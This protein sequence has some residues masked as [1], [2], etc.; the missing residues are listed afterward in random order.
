M[1]W[2]DVAKS[3][4]ENRFKQRHHQ[5]ARRVSSLLCIRVC[6]F[7][8]IFSAFELKKS[9]LY[10]CLVANRKG[11]SEKLLS[12]SLHFNLLKRNWENRIVHD[13]CVFFKGPSINMSRTLFERSCCFW[14]RIKNCKL[15]KYEILTSGVFHGSLH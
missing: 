6:A 8:N 2:F 15:Q 1:R 12:C 14:N 9:F 5:P 4:V 13:N 11:V 10:N 7:L 3:K